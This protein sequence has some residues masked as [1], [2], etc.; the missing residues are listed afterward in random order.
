MVKL[1]AEKYRYS[2]QRGDAWQLC[3]GRDTI[4]VS[5]LS[6]LQSGQPGPGLNASIVSNKSGL[7]GGVFPW[8]DQG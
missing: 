4:P 2:C 1:V 6:I 7:L 3:R 5:P 8:K